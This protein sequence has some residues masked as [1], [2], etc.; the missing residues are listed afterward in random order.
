MQLLYL[1]THLKKIKRKLLFWE[2]SGQHLNLNLRNQ[3]NEKNSNNSRKCSTGY[4]QIFHER[5]FKMAHQHIK[6][7]TTREDN[8]N[9]SNNGMLFHILVK[10]FKSL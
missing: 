8:A 6:K 3:I 10:K 1:K 4:G 2:K 9:Q 5:G 7:C